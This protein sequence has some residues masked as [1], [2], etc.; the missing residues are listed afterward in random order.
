MQNILNKLPKSVLNVLKILENNGYQA[1]IVGGAVRDALLSR[2]IGDFDICT[3]ALPIEIRKIFLEQK[4]K[5]IETG[6][7]H[8]T[9]SVVNNNTAYEITTFRA[10]G[11]YLDNRH[12]DKVIFNV[13]LEEDLK[14]R[15]F[16]INALACDAYGNIID[17]HDGIKDLR[18]KIIRTVGNPNDRFK[19]D[20]L[21]ILR[22]LRFKAVLGFTIEEKTKNAMFNKVE[23]V[24]NVSIERIN[25]EVKKILDCSYENYK[26][27]E[28]ILRIAY[29]YNLHLKKKDYNIIVR[30]PDYIM[31]I[32]YLYSF[33]DNDELISHLNSL[34][35]KNESKNLILEFIA[36]SKEYE[37]NYFDNYRIKKYLSK[38]GLVEGFLQIQY[39]CYLNNIDILYMKERI[40][41]LSDQV[42]SLKNLD[43]NGEDLISLGYSGKE[44][45]IILDNLLDLVL[46]DKVKNENK[47]LI[48]AIKRIKL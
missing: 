33:Y 27:Y 14:R 29:D 15:D 39:L 3:N 22:A 48:K 16:T 41:S 46:R 47:A 18:N 24:K 20:A 9:V 38:Y 4:Y 30:L 10:D 31:K 11:N 37:D 34:K 5:V 28:K 8:G 6:I 26:E 23:L 42:V 19:E 17:Y 35:L 7:K 21:R 40:D 43:I 45:G 32:A 13:S 2:K 36:N 25:Q 12:P 44:I 1:Y